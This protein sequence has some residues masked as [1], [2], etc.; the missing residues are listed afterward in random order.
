M[1]AKRAWSEEPRHRP[2]MAALLRYLQ[3]S[4]DA[5]A[6]QLVATRDGI[7]VSS[8]GGDDDEDVTAYSP[9]NAASVATLLSSSSR[10]SSEASLPCHSPQ[11]EVE[12][13]PRSQSKWSTIR[14]SRLLAFSFKTPLVANVFPSDFQAIPELAP[15]VATVHIV[16]L[17][18][19]PVLCPV[20]NH[21]LRY[22]HF[23]II[24]P[25]TGK[26]DH[27]QPYYLTHMRL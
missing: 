21:A 6:S 5:V 23:S 17:P 15:C 2:P 3:P 27:N 9:S 22:I 8:R 1:A 16:S 11:I 12:E 13:T 20:T 19:R 10:N 24:S 18:R 7:F 25:P 4:I 14:T 26:F